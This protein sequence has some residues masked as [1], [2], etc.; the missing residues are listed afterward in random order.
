MMYDAIMIAKVITIVLVIKPYF[1]GFVF[2]DVENCICIIL[3][4][5]DKITLFL[6]NI[7]ISVS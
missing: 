1:V 6:S 3:V 2:F 5:K 7:S 4:L